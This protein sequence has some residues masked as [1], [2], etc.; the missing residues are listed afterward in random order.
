VFYNNGLA[1]FLAS[2]R[3]VWANIKSHRRKQFAML[4]VLMIIASITE[5]ISIGVILPFLGMLTNPELVYQSEYVQPIIQI[6]GLNGPQQLLL[7][8]TI[9]FILAILVS[10]GMRVTLLWY[11]T[12]ISHAVGADLSIDI[13]RR[14]LYQSYSVH[15]ARNSSEIISAISQK[16]SHA[17]SGIIFPILTIIS[18]IFLMCAILFALFSIHF[19]AVF[20]SVVGFVII[21]ITIMIVTKKI[22]LRNGKIV[23][24]EQNQVFKALQEGLG[25]IRDIL[26]DSVQEVY[27]KAYRKSD[28]PLRRAHANIQIIGGIPRF[29]IEAMSMVM[30]SVLAF[31]LVRQ[32]D[33]IA[34]VIPML[35][36][37]AVGAQKLLPLFQNIYSSWVQIVGVQSSLTDVLDLLEQSIPDYMEESSPGLVQFKNSIEINK[38]SFSYLAHDSEVLND[39]SFVI[40]KGGCIGIVGSTGSGKSTLLD[41]L[42]GLLH[43]TK[44]ALSVDGTSITKRNSRGWQAHISH[45]PQVIFLADSTI[46]ENIAFGVPLE[47][48]DMDRVYMAAQKAQISQTISS[49]DEQYDTN[50]GEYGVRLSGGQRQRIGIARAL[51]KKADVIVLDEAT[52]AL[53]NSTESSVMETINNL[54]DE[55]TILIVAHRHTT[56][57]NCTQLIELENGNIKNI[58]TYDEIVLKNGVSK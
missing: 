12:R 21:Y 41:I 54:S 4:M 28:L 11:Q 29:A 30:I 17:V 42:M 55:V 3:R 49:W 52:S 27:C 34:I 40:P 43:P 13:Y 25:G 53:D 2:L 39:I 38:L 47:E 18:S 14:T 57:K 56:L 9:I 32:S 1:P 35:G 46:K 36:V 50:V 19:F 16:S 51:Y 23:S 33:N 10:G 58:G 37:L 31:F 15:I 5:V 24:L 20:S 22:I 8:V 48:I 45:V 6:L 26:I 44:G 7:P